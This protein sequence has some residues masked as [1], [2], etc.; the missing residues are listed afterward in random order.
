MTSTR[1][2]AE[3]ILLAIRV[4]KPGMEDTEEGVDVIEALLTQMLDE[5]HKEGGTWVQIEQV[6]RARA[7]ALTEGRLAALEEAAK[8]AETE[9]K[10]HALPVLSM[11]ESTELT[12]LR[13][14]DAIRQ[15]KRQ[16]DSNEMDK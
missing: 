4:G 9:Y 14:R 5:S 15:L 8:V 1:E 7:Q 16:V 13:I 11:Q 6:E 12:A 3:K 10:K 2:W